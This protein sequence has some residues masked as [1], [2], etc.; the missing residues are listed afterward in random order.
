[1]SPREAREL[2]RALKERDEEL[3]AVLVTHGHPD[4]FL[5]LGVMR[6]E[7][8]DVPFWVASSEIR[9]DIVNFTSWM[10]QVGW[11]DEEPAMKPKTEANPDGF[12]YA[13]ELQVR[14]LSELTLP[15]GGTIEARA[16]Y[17]ATECGHITTLWLP[18]ESVF[19]ASDLCYEGVHAWEGAG[20]ERAHVEAWADLCGK[21][22]IELARKGNGVRVCPG[23]GAPGGLERF[24]QM[25]T[26][27]LDFLAV[28]SSGATREEAAAVMT[29][30]YPDHL[31][32]E[33]LLTMSL[34]NHIPERDS[35]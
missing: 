17:P 2:A 3:T 26:Y 30:F 4:H 7:F 8:P 32:A 23:H 14:D 35:A 31:Q 13:K 20:V 16:D 15:S 6:T 24:A 25:R 28:I 5:G 34:E 12:D 21:L 22:R 11:L 1:M 18:R 19:L 27:L 10:Q 9:G 33:F 29:A